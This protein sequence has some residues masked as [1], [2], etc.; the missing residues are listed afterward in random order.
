MYHIGM[1]SH[2]LIC[3]LPSCD[4]C[5]AVAHLPLCFFY[6]FTTPTVTAKC[7]VAGLH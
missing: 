4:Y 6:Y 3:V 5:F 7:V 2:L 1:E